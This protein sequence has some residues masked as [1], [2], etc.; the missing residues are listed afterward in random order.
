MRYRFIHPVPLAR[1]HLPQDLSGIDVNLFKIHSNSESFLWWCSHVVRSQPLSLAQFQYL[2][3]WP[4]LVICQTVRL[5]QLM[6]HHLGE[7]LQ[8]SPSI[9]S[10]HGP[11]SAKRKD[12]E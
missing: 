8:Y 4:S 3:W 11:S 1:C 7:V 6:H 9:L 5:V 12:L 10:G 2:F